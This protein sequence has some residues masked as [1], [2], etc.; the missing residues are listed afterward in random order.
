MPTLLR[1]K[2]K[3]SIIGVVALWDACIVFSVDQVYSNSN[4]FV[5]KTSKFSVGGP[6]F[7]ISV[8]PITTSSI[9]P[10]ALL[11]ANSYLL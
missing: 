9:L 8:N 5:L 4:E 2:T 10:A 6:D 1:H 7:R 3:V 11:I